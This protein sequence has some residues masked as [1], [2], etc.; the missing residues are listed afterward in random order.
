M[1]TVR[2]V[3][4]NERDHLSYVQQRSFFVYDGIDIVGTACAYCLT[5]G[6][7]N[8]GQPSSNA[9]PIVEYSHDAPYDECQ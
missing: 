1:R 6:R 7:T 2:H 4:R 3:E 9:A 8:A 5:L